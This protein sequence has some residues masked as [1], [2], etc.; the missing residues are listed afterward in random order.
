[1]EANNLNIPSARIFGFGY[2]RHRLGWIVEFFLITEQ[3][4]SH[5]DGTHWL[6]TEGN[7]PKELI[8]RAL[9]LILRLHEC[10]FIHLDPWIA[11]FMINPNN[12][13]DIR[14]VD[15]ENCILAPT[16]HFLET[17]GIQFG[18]LYRRVVCDY[19]AEEHFDELVKHTV[20]LQE[21]HCDE[22]FWRAYM[23]SKREKIAR[24]SRRRTPLTGNI[25]P[26]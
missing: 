20:M 23:I 16:Q 24:K 14:I 6:A 19:V 3:L 4:I 2:V 25:A 17:L 22:R 18:I 13:D 26:G 1:M 8:S 5:V 11:N 9:T 12:L 15:L 21:V 10:D 7:D